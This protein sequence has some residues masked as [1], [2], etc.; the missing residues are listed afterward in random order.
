MILH[1][2]F[3][4]VLELQFTAV[5]HVIRSKV[6][7]L[8]Q[9]TCRAHVAFIFLAK[10]TVGAHGDIAWA[11]AC[12]RGFSQGL[13]FACHSRLTTSTVC[14]DLTIWT[15]HGLNLTDGLQDRNSVH[16]GENESERKLCFSVL[17]LKTGIA[18]S[19]QFPCSEFHC[20]RHDTWGRKVPL[21]CFY[22]THW[23]LKNG[24][25]YYENFGLIHKKLQQ[26]EHL[27]VPRREAT[28]QS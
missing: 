7:M 12:F 11:A 21:S 19:V 27:W 16:S 5:R 25:K 6:I 2:E 9:P 20:E 1:S 15:L 14:Q 3:H 23:L 4:K 28:A 18:Q 24:K 10:V 17:P 22:H 26:W 8:V 13:R